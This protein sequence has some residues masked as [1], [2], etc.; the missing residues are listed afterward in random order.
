MTDRTELGQVLPLAAIFMTALLLMAA[1]A[2]DVTSVLSSERFYTTTAEAAALAGAQ[3]LQ[4]AT[5]RQIEETERTRSRDHAMSVLVNRLEATSTPTAG[6]CDPENDIVDC[7]LPGTPY[8]VSIQT[9]SPSCVTCEPFRSVQVTIRNPAHGLTF[10]GLVGQNDW[11]VE[12]DAVAGLQF[13]GKYAIQTLR[14]PDPQPNG[15]DQNRQNISIDGT[16]TWVNV[17]RGDVG[18]NTSVSTTSG[19][20]I[21][22]DS[23]A[24]YRI[25][26]IDDIVPD[27]WN[28]VN[29]LPEGKLLLRLIPDPGYMIADFDGLP[30][31]SQGKPKAPTYARQ[32]DGRW[33]ATYGPDACPARGTEGFP[34]AEVVPGEPEYAAY[35]DDPALEVTCYLPGVYMDPQG[36]VVNQNT[37]VAYLLPG[38]YYFGSKGISVT[39]TL[40]GGL[41]ANEPGVVLVVPQDANFTGNNSV[42]IILNQGNEA[43]DANECRAAPAEDWSGDAVVSPDGLGL[44]IQIPRDPTNDICFDD[45]TPLN[46]N[47]CTNGNNTLNL[48]GTGNLSISGVIY[49]PSDN[50]QFNGNNTSQIGEVGQIIA[51]TATY[52]GGAK[53]NQVYPEPDQVGTVRLDAACTASEVCN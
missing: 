11:N 22:L 20:R 15:A 12:A 33:D 21:T 38:A 26:H 50:I 7:A 31:P 47:A 4:K 28:Q 1:L 17:T 48:P 35:L 37:E 29:G 2:V 41:V 19:G 39:G 13:S 30:D 16:N 51:W 46:V 3:D 36:F 8:L 25:E 34:P 40:L 10:A 6:T 9:P 32:E 45:V 53:L 44:T 23:A 52:G 24:G 42:A 27:P 5:S 43:C 49:A 18:T 14:P